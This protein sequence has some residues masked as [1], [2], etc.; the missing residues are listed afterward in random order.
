MNNKSFENDNDDEFLDEFDKLLSHEVEDDLDDDDLDDE[1]DDEMDDELIV[2]LSAELAEEE[3]AYVDV[4]TDARTRLT[5]ADLMHR[6]VHQADDVALGD[7]FVLS[8]LSRAEMELVEQTWRDIPVKR[9]SRLIEWLVDSSNDHFELQLGRLLRIALRDEDA[10]VRLLALSGLEE[11]A[12]P[13]LIGPLSFLLRQDSDEDV[14]AAAASALGTFVLAG[15]LDELDSALAMRAEEALLVAYQSAEEQIIVQARAL[16]SLAYSS[17][18]GLRQM[19]EDAYYSS[20][21]EMRVSAV[22][23]MGR[24]ADTRWRNLVRA[25]LNSPDA[26]MRAEAARS[27]GELE[28]KTAIPQIILMLDDDEPQVRHAAIEALGHLGGKAARD[29]LRAIAD[30]DDAREAIAAE[31]A[32]DELL[33]LDD[34]GAVS[35]LGEEEEE[36]DGYEED[37]WQRGG[38]R[39][40]T[41]GEGSRGE[42]TSNSAYWDRDES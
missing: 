33:L 8:D 22:R 29:A 34:A 12:Q 20:H 6:L 32:L 39:G 16:E 3:A 41:R 11:D 7:L 26:A 9:R 17:E 21:E 31:E 2:E 13:D 35:L 23:A 40:G 37:Y 4:V 14:R 30:G 25:E 42:G 36:E 27:A 24:S 18:A 15:E 5:V 28:A 19:I 10:R 38:T 1:I